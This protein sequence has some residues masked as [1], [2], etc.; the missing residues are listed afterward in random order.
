M[1]NGR[2]AFPPA[3]QALLRE[4]LDTVCRPNAHILLSE[5]MT[6]SF[7]HSPAACGAP[8]V[9]GAVSDTREAPG[10]T[11]HLGPPCSFLGALQ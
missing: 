9:V 3:P 6:S 4:W 11:L 5:K 10:G 1:G 8:V 2:G 7:S